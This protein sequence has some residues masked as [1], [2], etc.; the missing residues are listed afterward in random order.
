MENKEQGIAP[1]VQQTESVS[2]Q[3]E[4]KDS[5]ID[6]NPLHGPEA[7]YD[8]AAAKQAMQQSMIV[9]PGVDQV[10]EPLTKSAV[11]VEEKEKSAVPDNGFPAGYGPNE[12]MK[13]IE[14]KLDGQ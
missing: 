8:R 14:K 2:Y 13:R 9:E 7:E 6:M 4:V 1:Q 12:H 5:H 10:V 3:E 11:I